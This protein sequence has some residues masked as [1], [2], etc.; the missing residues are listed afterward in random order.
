MSTGTEGWELASKKQAGADITA[1]KESFSAMRTSGPVP[2]SPL[3]LG[4]AGSSGASRG[5]EGREG[6]GGTAADVNLTVIRVTTDE[7]FRKSAG[8]EVHVLK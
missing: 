2:A 6:G 8:L 7:H 5:R 3:N 1:F 4:G